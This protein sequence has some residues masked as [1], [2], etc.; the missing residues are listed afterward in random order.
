M[1]LLYYWRNDN[2]RRDL[3]NGMG[4]HLN[5][6][7]KLLHAID[8]GDSLWAFT[9][10]K[11][12]RFVMAAEL[13]I[14]AKT[15]NQPCFRYGP[16]RVWGDLKQSRYFEVEQ[17][18]SMEQIIR[19]LSPTANAAILSQSFQGNAALRPLTS[20]DHQKLVSA[21]RTLLLEPRA[22]L[23]PEERLE[24]TLLLGDEQAVIDLLQ[25][26]KPG[27]IK[28]R[29]EYLYGKAITRNRDLVQEL[30]KLYDG[31]CQ[32]C[33]WGP[34]SIYGYPLCHGH[35]IQWLSRGGDDTIRNL[36][37]L[38]PNHHAAVHR[39]DAPLD[40]LDM[41]FD[42]GKFRDKLQLDQHISVSS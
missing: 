18:P 2:Y 39:C 27:I 41:A 30:Q 15:K 38:C 21:S 5:S 33:G 31:R 4:Y 13:I 26:E 19:L 20:T 7:N 36:M 16:Y 14:R 11:Q 34:R 9:R 6:K 37:L 25:E 1:P 23:L 42:F 24:A 3:D 28:E 8:V 12:K 29:Q 40:Y 32:L 22:R 17:Q 35:H 10:N